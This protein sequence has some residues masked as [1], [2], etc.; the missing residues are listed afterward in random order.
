MWGNPIAKAWLLLE[1]TVKEEREI[2]HWDEK[3]AAFQELGEVAVRQNPD[4][5]KRRSSFLSDTAMGGTE[6]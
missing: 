1:P 2:S 3:W 5:E 6:S 4:V